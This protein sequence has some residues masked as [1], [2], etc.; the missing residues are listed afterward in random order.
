MYEKNK[1]RCEA[2]KTRYKEEESFFSVI[3]ARNR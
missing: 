1:I 3:H 2:F